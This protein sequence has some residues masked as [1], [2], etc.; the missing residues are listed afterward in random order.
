MEPFDV[1]IVGSGLAG[2]AA[3]LQLAKTCRVAILSEKTMKNASTRHAQGGIAAVWAKNDSLNAHL[4]D[5]LVAGAGLCDVDATKAILSRGPEAIQWLL[6]KG[7]PL[8]HENHTEKLHLTREGGHSTRRIAHAE[9]ATGLTIH[10][11]LITAVKATPNISMFENMHVIDVLTQEADTPSGKR[12]CGVLALKSKDN[13]IIRFPASHVILATGGD[14]RIYLHT[15][16]SDAPAGSGIAMAWRAKCRVANLEFTQFHP[17]SFFDPFGTPFLISEAVRGEGGVLLLPESSPNQGERFML[18]YDERAELAPRDIVARAIDHEMKNYELDHVDLDISHLP[19]EFLNEHFPTILAHCAERGIDMTKRPIPVVPAAHYTCGGILT[20]YSGQTDLPHLFAIG[21]TAYTGL[22]GA[23]RLAS[24]SLLE[25]LVTSFFVTE[26][27]ESAQHLSV[28]AQPE[29]EDIP[30]NAETAP[31]PQ[32]KLLE[33]ELKK[34]MWQ[35]VGIV[36]N[37]KGLEDAHNEIE[38]LQD[39]T[40][41]LTQKYRLSPEL[42][43]LTNL[44]TAARLTIDSARSRHESRGLHYNVDYPD[45]LPNP[46]PTVL[47]PTL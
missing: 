44:M 19:K 18:N 22:H 37:N 2:L 35:H 9:D 40:N 16:H 21:E 47:T 6:N 46:A 1:L 14:S 23:N 33:Y 26:A 20:G 4:Q 12:A 45:K 29:A 32:V 8:S 41:A 7:V 34:L 15:T 24:N 25:C 10:E 42:I 27:I 17:T 43:D 39:Q 13:Q 5:T 28:K 11:T 31:S 30:Y 36:R 38:I 3:A